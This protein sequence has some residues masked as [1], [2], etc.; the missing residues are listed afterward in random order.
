MSHFLGSPA[1]RNDIGRLSQ[2]G[3]PRE[4]HS[5]NFANKSNEVGI[6]VHVITAEDDVPNPSF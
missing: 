5:R 1:Y 3:W 4:M 2:H 6:E